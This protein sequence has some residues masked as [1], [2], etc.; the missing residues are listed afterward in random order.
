LHSTLELSELEA[1]IGQLFMA[2]MPGPDLDL[3][4]ESLIR[5]H[6]LGGVIFFARN[7]ENPL[8]LAALCRDLQ[9]VAVVSQGIP[10]FLAVDQ[11]GGRV[12]RLREPFTVFPGN[13]AIGEDPRSVDRAREF[14]EV[15]AR[16]MRLVG[17]NMDLAPVVDVRRGEPER[18]L[19]GRTFGDEPAKVAL[20]GRTVVKSLQKNGVMAVAKHFPGLGFTSVDPHQQLPTI[21]ADLREIEEINLPPFKAAMEAGVSAVMTSH[22]VYPALDPQ[23]PAT[24]SKTVLTGLL[25]ESLGFPGL[26]ITDDL[27]MGA[28]AKEWGVPESAANA[29]EAGADILLICG[30]QKSVLESFETVKRKL[31]RSDLPLKR[32]KESA[33]RIMAAKSRFLKKAERVVLKEVKAYFG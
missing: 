26:T 14:G 29:F 17:L 21:S 11:E 2:G 3:G 28:V 10:L 33:E 23:R 24:L 16:E 15:T 27:E 9:E 18:H 32:L 5:D 30:E 6:G 13:E 20:L 8:Q 12:A 4:T 25:R 19:A 22:A 31:I 7:I 1:K